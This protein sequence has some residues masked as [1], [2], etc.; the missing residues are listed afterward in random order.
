MGNLRGKLK[1]VRQNTKFISLRIYNTIFDIEISDGSYIKEISSFLETHQW[2]DTFSVYFI[3]SFLDELII[4]EVKNF[5]EKIP[6][7]K[8]YK[9]K[10]KLL[11]FITK[12]TLCNDHGI[13]IDF[14]KCK[15]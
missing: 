4:T 15:S 10:K 11:I 3:C 2:F 8:N 9:M 13:S 12:S 1:K 6:Q 5:S 14:E 7:I